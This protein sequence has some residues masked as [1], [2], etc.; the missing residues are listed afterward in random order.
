[1]VGRQRD[2]LFASYKESPRERERNSHLL[3]AYCVPDTLVDHIF[4]FLLLMFLFFFL[5]FP[6]TSSFSLSPTV[7]LIV[8]YT[9][10]SSYIPFFLFILLPLNHFF[11]LPSPLLFLI[12]QFHELIQCGLPVLVWHVRNLEVIPS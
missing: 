4:P 6:F 12:I 2:T 10:M 8:P 1:M 5:L 7:S 11:P 3:D 9:L